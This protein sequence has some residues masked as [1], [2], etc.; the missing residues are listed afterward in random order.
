MNNSHAPHIPSR[1][2]RKAVDAEDARLPKVAICVPSGDTV[3]KGFA[4]ALAALSYTCGPHHDQPAIPIALVG[5]EGSLIVRNR[6]ESI[7]QA[8]A[9]GCDYVLFLDSDM[10]FPPVTL[11]RLLAHGKEIV[12]ATYVQREP[13]H[14]LLGKFLPDT[15]LTSDRLHE[16]EALPAGC[17]LIKL[18]V[19]DGMAKP[20]FRTE[21]HEE[22]GDDPAWFEGED[23]YFCRIA[24][25]RGHELW[26]DVGLSMQLGHIG[27]FV[28][29]IAT[30]RA[31][32]PEE[33]S[34][35]QAV[36]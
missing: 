15:M 29:T 13:P 20:Y 22:Q 32:Q 14:R 11:R 23:Y 36:H 34:H 35:G 1:P 10:Q 8:Q 25:E 27:R 21:A 26:L 2:P 12:G 7:A 4:M 9:L 33:A 3:C 31:E 16:V 17:L 24:R 28:N 6:C 19:F 5:T 30:Q 18:S